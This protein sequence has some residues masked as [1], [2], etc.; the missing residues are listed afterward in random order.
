MTK[1]YNVAVLKTYLALKISEATTATTTGATVPAT[2]AVETATKTTA[3]ARSATEIIETPRFLLHKG[4]VWHC[5][6]L[7][8]VY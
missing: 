4:L 1:R 2:T 7:R 3:M 8:V 6:S 5:L